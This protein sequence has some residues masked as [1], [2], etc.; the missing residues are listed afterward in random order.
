M[1]PYT[2]LL[3][4]PEIDKWYYGVRYAKKCHPSD[5]WVTYKTSSRHVDS[6]VKQKKK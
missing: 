6:I 4:W 5:L 1:I 3:G 2:Y